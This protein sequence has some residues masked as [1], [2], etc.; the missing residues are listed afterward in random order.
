MFYTPVYEV[1]AIETISKNIC[2]LLDC[3]VVWMA[4]S[5]VYSSTMRMFYDEVLC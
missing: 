1:C 3:V 4:N 5:I 2:V